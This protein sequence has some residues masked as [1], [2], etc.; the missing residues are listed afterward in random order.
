L[1]TKEHVEAT[2]LRD[3]NTE[4]KAKEYAQVVGHEKNNLHLW[5]EWLADFNVKDIKIF[6]T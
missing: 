6:M 5:H 1:N 3:N 4:L 2:D